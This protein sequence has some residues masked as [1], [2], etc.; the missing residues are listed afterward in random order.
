MCKRSENDNDKDKDN[1]HENK[2][3]QKEMETE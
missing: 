1:H 2:I 3:T